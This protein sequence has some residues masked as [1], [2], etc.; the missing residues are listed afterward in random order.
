[1]PHSP[2]AR[3]S[4]LVAASALV[5]GTLAGVAFAAPAQAAECKPVSIISARGTFEPQSGSWLQKPVGDQIAAA[6]PGQ[7][8]YT[9]LPYPAAP[10]FDTSPAA[11]VTA[12]VSLLNSEAVACPDQRYIL[13]GYSQGAQVTG[14]SL[15]PPAKR[16]AGQGA[17][18]VSA[19]ASARI[20][21]VVFYGNPR[22]VAGEPF[23]AGNP[24]PGK[25]G[26]KPRG[27]G[28]LDAYASRIRDFCAAGDFVCQQGGGV[29]AHLLYFFNGTVA[30]GARFAVQKI[31]G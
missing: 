20:A 29:L 8:K 1:M 25:S 12:L 27:K 11:G 5:A 18:E 21:A 4:A 24:E 30:E 31:N 16:L 10:N 9:E 7:T 17:G 2:S 15:V 19:A 23:N 6:L 14:D 22:F 28:D 13:I 3:S 26:D